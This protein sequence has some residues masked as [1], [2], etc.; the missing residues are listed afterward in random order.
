[1]FTGRGLLTINTATVDG[2]CV[3]TVSGVLD[4]TTYVPLRDAIKKAALDRPRA[5][6][7]DIAGLIVVGGSAWAVFPATSWYISDGPD[8][9]IGLICDTTNGRRALC[10]N[11]AY[12]YVPAYRTL[13]AA[14][15]ELADGDSEPRYRRR[16]RAELPAVK[17]IPG[18]VAS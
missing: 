14:I 11:G 8:V 12:R 9:P 7:V 6:L 18:T 16:A 1:V 13:E 2:A 17:G 10:R 4:G 3:L 15:A 5:V